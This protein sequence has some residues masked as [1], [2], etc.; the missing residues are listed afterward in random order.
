[1]TSTPTATT[2]R[3][4]RT[5]L[6]SIL[7]G[8]LSVIVVPL[9]IVLATNSWSSPGPED[10]VRMALGGVVAACVSVVGAW[11]L[12][13]DRR[14]AGAPGATWFWGVACLVTL[15]AVSALQST[16]DRLTALITG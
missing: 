14:R 6:R 13:F 4:P 5:Y 8:A 16:A 12:A 2:T 3:P 9:A 1:M 7:L 10:H 15:G 11:W